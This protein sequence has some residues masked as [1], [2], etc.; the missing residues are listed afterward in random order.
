MSMATMKGSS[1]AVA[2]TS[3]LK[4]MEPYAPANAARTII[5]CRYESNN[6]S[7][8]SCKSRLYESGRPFKVT[9][10]PVRL[11]TSRPHFARASSATSL[12]FFWGNID[13]P[14]AYSSLKTAKLNSVDVHKTNSSP[15]RERC[16]PNSAMSKSVS[17]TKSRSL[18]ASREFVKAVVNPSTSATK[19]GSI[20]S[21]VPARAPA[22]SGDT[23][24]RSRA[25][26]SRS[27]SRNSAH[28]CVQ[29]M[30]ES[31]RL[32]ALQVGVSRQIDLVVALTNGEEYVNQCEARGGDLGDRVPGEK[33]K[34]GGHLVVATARG[35]EF[36][37]N[38]PR[39]FDDSTFN[40][41]MNV[42]VARRSFETA[43]VE[44]GQDL[45]ECPDQLRSLVCAHQPGAHQALHVRLG[46]DDVVRIEHVVEGVT[47]RE[48]PETALHCGRE[49]SAPQRHGDGGV[50]FLAP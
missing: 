41:H 38:V 3:L 17:A 33:S 20:G 45:I 27:T 36:R 15:I 8:S 22:P 12:F 6:G 9:R 7:L 18:T 25:S 39:E 40:R 44:L 37:P 29:V 26:K 4:V 23:F 24:M 34:G 31:N 28:A 43:V 13:E 30:A 19:D 1:A 35:M 49:S 21:E 16:T 32:R 48:V 50:A 2:A 46:P 42:L 47:L 14:V 11:P 5:T 10:R